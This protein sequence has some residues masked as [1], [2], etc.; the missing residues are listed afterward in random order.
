MITFDGDFG[1]FSD[2]VEVISIDE[3]MFELENRHEILEMHLE[4]IIKLMMCIDLIL[5]IILE[6]NM[7]QCY[8]CLS[9]RI[10][11]YNI[12]RINFE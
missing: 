11:V 10:R 5:N 4:D 8:L 12:V 9:L 7:F 3:E 2:V 1:C 6:L